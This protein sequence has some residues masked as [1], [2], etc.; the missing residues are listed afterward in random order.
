MNQPALIAA[1]VCLLLTSC[2]SHKKTAEEPKR[3]NTNRDIHSYSQPEKVRVKHLDLDCEVLF[4]KK[5]LKGSATLSIEH[6]VDAGQAPLILDT[7][8]LT[9]DQTSR[10]RLATACSATL[11]MNWDPR[12]SIWVRR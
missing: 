5:I 8:D 6:A 11:S 10:P 7:R 3:M 1:G 9:I 4:D 2:V 12:T